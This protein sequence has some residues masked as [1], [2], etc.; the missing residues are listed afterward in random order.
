MQTWM[1]KVGRV[2]RM[3][4]ARGRTG[5]TGVVLGGQRVYVS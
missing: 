1:R 4:E 3:L 2:V 5:S